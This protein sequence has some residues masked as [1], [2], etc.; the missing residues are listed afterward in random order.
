MENVKYGERSKR[1]LGRTEQFLFTKY[2]IKEDE[3]KGEL[4]R[5]EEIRNP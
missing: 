5:T 3:M 1:K 4:S 2:Q